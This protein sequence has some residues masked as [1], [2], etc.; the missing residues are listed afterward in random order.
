MSL[1]T[2]ITRTI[3]EHRQ[4]RGISQEALAQQ[5]GRGHNHIA[6]WERGKGPVQTFT[7]L[8]RI[9]DVLDLELVVRPKDTSAAIPSEPA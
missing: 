2:T 1:Y 9:L 4:S 5:L 7:D 8:E 6:L 3:R